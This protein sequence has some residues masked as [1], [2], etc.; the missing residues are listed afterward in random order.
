MYVISHNGSKECYIYIITKCFVYSY[1][2]SSSKLLIIS[3]Q[4]NSRNWNNKKI[5]IARFLG[6]YKMLQASITKIIQQSVL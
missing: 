1:N 2:Y 5:H 3:V 4:K 6:W